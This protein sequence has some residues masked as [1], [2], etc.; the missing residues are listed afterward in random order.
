MSLGVH[1]E[2]YTFMRLALHASRDSLRRRPFR[3]ALR[4]RRSWSA[5]CAGSIVSEKTLTQEYLDYLA[6]GP[7][8]LQLIHTFFESMALYLDSANEISCVLEAQKM[9]PM[10]GLDF[11]VN[12]A[13]AHQWWREMK[14][15]VQAC[16]FQ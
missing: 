1:G 3:S 16:G 14:R 8:L 15:V 12:Y 6:S 5:H 9:Y 7:T 11:R 4:L 2:V 13:P 10:N